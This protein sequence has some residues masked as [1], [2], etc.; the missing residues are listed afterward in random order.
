MSSA[1]LDSGG[2]GGR[3]SS[4][5]LAQFNSAR[6]AR[7]AYFSGSNGNG[8]GD[9]QNDGDAPAWTEWVRVDRV[10]EWYIYGR[11]HNT[12]DRVQFH[13]TGTA[14]DG[15]RIFLDTDGTVVDNIVVMD[16]MDKVNA[17]LEA[18]FQRDE[19]GDVP[20]DDKPTGSDPGPGPAAPG[21]TGPGGPSSAGG[22]P[23]VRSLP[24]VGNFGTIGQA[25]VVILI[26][27]AV[28]YYR[29]DGDL[30]ELPIVGSQFGGESA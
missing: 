8:D 28:Y 14:S 3:S 26:V 25:I 9:D 2:G 27:F 23:L 21:G 6:A 24:I 30:S 19:D 1:K 20:D 5:G 29:N 10:A 17:A 18:Y 13:I 22:I 7:K 12:E 16:S 15:R 4:G 11:E